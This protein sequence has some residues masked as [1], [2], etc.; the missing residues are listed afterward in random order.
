V[1]V[2]YP[3]TRDGARAAAANYAIAYGSSAMFHTDKRHAIVDAIADPAVKPALQAQLDQSFTAVMA[4][5]GLDTTGNPPQGETFV[6]RT[7]PVGVHLLT[8]TTTEAQV[9]VWS[10][11]VVGL[12]GA[13][14]T[15]PVTE[16]WSTATI[17]LHWTNGDW[18]WV[19]F[20]QTDGPTPVGGVQTPSNA[21]D[22]ADAVKDFEGLDYAR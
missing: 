19:A 10:V 3:D 13:G 22:I 20:T 15:L 11:G 8:Y 9:A 18:K 5:F 16:A 2:G 21:G 6:D 12:A 17:T 7:V 4:R 14:S 1:P